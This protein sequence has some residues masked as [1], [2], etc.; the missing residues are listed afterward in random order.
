MLLLQA[1]SDLRRLIAAA[2]IPILVTD[3]NLVVLEANESSATVFDHDDLLGRNLADDLLVAAH[4]ADKV[5]RAIRRGDDASTRSVGNHLGRVEARKISDGSK[6]FL[7]LDVI[8]TEA[9]DGGRITWLFQDVT[10]L[11]EAL[12][13]VQ[14]QNKVLNQFAH[15][16]RNKNAAAGSMLDQIV[17]LMASHRETPEVLRTELQKLES[18]MRLSMALID[19]GNQLI[20]TRLDLHKVYQVRS[21]S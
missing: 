11:D 17:H 12:D 9:V 2:G 4:E 7:L 5:R 15:E 20:R 6:L 10:A 16:I 19:E 14:I 13:E 3:D 8:A 21:L 18:D 1:T